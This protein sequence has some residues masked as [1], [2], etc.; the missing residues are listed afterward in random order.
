MK[1]WFL[2]RIGLPLLGALALGAG[3]AP[4]ADPAPTVQPFKI[5]QT[6]PLTFP[7]RLINDGILHGEARIAF[8]VDDRGRLVDALAVAYSAKEFAESAL[9]TLRRW[10]FVPTRIGDKTF[11]NVVHLTIVYENNGTVALVRNQVATSA[12]DP[13][14]PAGTFLYQPCSPKSLDRP[15]RAQK[16]VT[17]DYPGAI[18]RQGIAGKVRVSFYVDEK[19]L[20][21]MAVCAADAHPAL[22]PLAI[23]AVEA[24]RFEP[25]TSRGKPV[26]VSV[27]QEFSFVATD[28]GPSGGHEGGGAAAPAE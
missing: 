9:D 26:L 23:A 3:W 27:V 21:R 28:A 13:D 15:L 17:P 22:A 1:P 6:E 12:A 5:I 25:P 20:P 8:Q 11:A 18:R 19:G 24:W 14:A 7:L 10:K 16:V 4:A 2:L